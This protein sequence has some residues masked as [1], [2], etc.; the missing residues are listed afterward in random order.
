M[1]KREKTRQVAMNIFYGEYKDV[2]VATEAIL[3]LFPEPS[4]DD[5]RKEIDFIYE[6]YWHSGEWK[7]NKYVIKESYKAFREQL[8]DALSKLQ[9]KGEGEGGKEL[10]MDL[11]G[12]LIKRI[13]E[14]NPDEHDIELNLC[15]I[16]N[17]A[18]PHPEKEGVC[19]H[20]GDKMGGSDCPTICCKCGKEL[21]GGKWINTK[22]LPPQVSNTIDNSFEQFIKNK[23]GQKTEIVNIIHISAE[24]K[25]YEAEKEI[26]RSFPEYHFDFSCQEPPQETEKRIK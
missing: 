9:I 7:N 17:K 1:D 24:K 22:P 16:I 14:F 19:E 5:V 2:D 26:M 10:Y 11:C 15:G 18:K 23:L 21:F 12:R 4:V 6:L 25:D 3:A 13:L 8:I 20:D